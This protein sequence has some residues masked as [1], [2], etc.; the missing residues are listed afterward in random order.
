MQQIRDLESWFNQKKGAAAFAR[1]L[2]LNQHK[3]L[4]VETP[5]TGCTKISSLLILMNRGYEDCELAD[6]L[7]TTPAS[8]YHWE[9]GIPDNQSYN[10]Q[11]LSTLFNNP[12][13][14]KFAFVRNPYDRIASAYADRIY[15][16]HLKDYEYYIDIAKKIK[17]EFSWKPICLVAVLTTKIDQLINA[18]I[19]F[20][21]ASASLA[22]F[23]SEKDY[24][25]KKLM[26]MPRLNK[27]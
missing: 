5:K 23:D 9:F 26:I 20:P 6:F 1:I 7:T 25:P 11:E 2:I 13:Y 18:V 4:Y 14:F 16:P 17:A 22:R 3:L 12:N 10:S 21:K 19:T 27:K 15:A 8:Y 24:L